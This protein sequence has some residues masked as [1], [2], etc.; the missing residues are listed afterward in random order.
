MR[1]QTLNTL[2]VSA[3]AVPAIAVH[4]MREAINSGMFQPGERL[5]E[6]D[7]CSRL[8]I[9]RPSL[10]EALRALEA[11]KLVVITPN[12]G[13]SIPI[14]TAEEAREIYGVRALLEGE[15]VA[16]AAKHRPDAAVS[17]MRSA[18]EDF[19]RAV[20][21]RDLDAQIRSTR[22]F[23]DQILESCGQQLICELL[24]T[25]MVRITFLRSRSM[26]Q[27]GRPEKSSREMWAIC[28]HI[29]SRDLDRARAAS[30]RH[31]VKASEAAM[32]DFAH[33]TSPGRATRSR[34]LA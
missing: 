22:L 14:L 16:L 17:A 13:P 9:S 8:G 4:A 31:V 1:T 21:R 27:E 20:A 26:S 32:K 2:K 15:A 3:Q 10:R 19:D 23:Y 24:S 18:L 30:V 25:L 5:V 6:A 12:K 29:A 34:R 11:Q 7:M 28:R 33:E